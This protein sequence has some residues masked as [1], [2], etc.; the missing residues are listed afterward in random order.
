[1]TVPYERIKGRIDYRPIPCL[2]C[3]AITAQSVIDHC[4]EHGWTRG[5]L[6]IGC[7]NRMARV[8][9]DLRIASPPSS[10]TVTTAGVS[11]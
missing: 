7:N 2:M 9:A 6:C 10:S 11:P 5:V 1:M 4:H 3:T 8:D